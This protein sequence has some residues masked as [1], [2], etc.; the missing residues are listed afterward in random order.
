MDEV[1]DCELL[2]GSGRNF[3]CEHCKERFE[4]DS[5]LKAH[6]KERHSPFACYCGAKFAAARYLSKHQSR[7][8]AYPKVPLQAVRSN[9]HQQHR[10]ERTPEVAQCRRKNTLHG[11][12]LRHVVQIQ[13]DQ[14]HDKDMKSDTLYFARPAKKGFTIKMN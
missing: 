3:E 12:R 14:A 1:S 5:F 7:H 13:H 10:N 2:T 6:L 8:T 4:S 11:L 9:V